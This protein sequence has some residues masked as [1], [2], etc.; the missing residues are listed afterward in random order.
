[1]VAPIVLWGFVYGPC[2]VVFC[3]HLVGEKRA[4][5]FTLIAFDVM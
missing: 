5:S 3:N 1:M 4:G 2:F